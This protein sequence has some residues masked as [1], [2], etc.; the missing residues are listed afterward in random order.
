MDQQ[1]L[2]NNFKRKILRRVGLAV[3]VMIGFFALPFLPHLLP[4]NFR[5]AYPVIIVLI[6]VGAV[7]IALY[8]AWR[9]LRISGK[10]LSGN[11]KAEDVDPF[12]KGA[13]KWFGGDL[14]ENPLRA[15]DNDIPGGIPAAATVLACRQGNQKISMG[16]KEYYQLV[17]DVT[18]HDG[19]SWP[20]T[21][22]QMVPITQVGLFQPGTRF[23]VKYDPADRSR[24]VLD[25]GQQAAQTAVNIP[26]Q[27][28]VDGS[29]I[30]A[31][32]QAAPA[33]ITLRLQASS[34]LLNELQA[35]GMPASAEVLRQQVYH[36]NYLPGT[37]AV[38]IRY[39][40]RPGGGA[41][42]E[43]EQLILTPK[44]AL[45]KTMFGSTI[46]V[47]YDPADPR[48]VAISGTGQQDSA[49]VL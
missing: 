25:I 14:F 24:V 21:I 39:R 37:D 7:G 43:S 31:A 38:N 30:A 40:Y 6:V 1:T 15:M 8:A 41:A 18:V 34:L 44:S 9:A 3:L 27:G 36:E 46:H 20:A 16:V 49:V 32:K 23:A 28:I 13:N 45:H 5:G 42:L 33:D 17:I 10:L 2:L 19:E 22:K 48:R 11:L 47:R 26:G 29:V 12:V 4:D 35:A